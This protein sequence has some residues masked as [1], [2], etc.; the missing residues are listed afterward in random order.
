MRWQSADACCA[1]SSNNTAAHYAAAFGWLEC[2]KRLIKRGADPNAPNDWKTTPLG[3]AMQKGHMAIADYLLEQ[4]SVDVNIRDDD[5]KTLVA[6]M[7]EVITG[8]TLKQLNYL[9]EKKDADVT[10]ADAQ[11]YT[12]LHHLAKNYDPRKDI[13]DNSNNN[14]DDDDNDVYD[15][16]EQDDEAGDVNVD[17]R[18][19]QEAAATKARSRVVA[20]QLRVLHEDDWPEEGK[21]PTTTKKKKKL[22]R[23]SSIDKQVVE[24]SWGVDEE[25]ERWRQMNP[26]VFFDRHRAS[27]TGSVEWLVRWDQIRLEPD[28]REDLL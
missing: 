6:Q 2:L 16:D 22:F 3:I 12:P 13:N 28:R 8:S 4:D 11:G 5:G 17:S 9:L 20:E 14:D 25:E 19:P 10:T 21:G 7:T 1:D 15:V 18:P 23:K 27:R 24:A 26:A